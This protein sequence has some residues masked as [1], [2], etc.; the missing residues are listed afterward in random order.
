MITFFPKVAFHKRLIGLNGFWT[1]R[2]FRFAA[3]ST[4]LASAILAPV[5]TYAASPTKRQLPSQQDQDYESALT[6]AKKLDIITGMGV[7]GIGQYCEKWGKY[8]RSEISELAPFYPGF[9]AEQ[10][11]KPWVS[12]DTPPANAYPFRPP[13]KTFKT[14]HQPATKLLNGIDWLGDRRLIFAAEMGQARGR[15]ATDVGARDLEDLRRVNRAHH[16]PATRWHPGA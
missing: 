3:L 4:L 6:G 7:S 2:L 10:L 15:I 12:N 14:Q 8:L 11:C 13:R 16:L 5:E 9:V 1:P